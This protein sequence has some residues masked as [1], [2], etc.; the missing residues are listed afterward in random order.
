MLE[1]GGV[2]HQVWAD[3]AESLAL[4]F[5]YAVSEQLLGVGFWALGYDDGHEPLWSELEERYPPAIVEP[6]PVDEG[7]G[8]KDAGSWDA[9][10]PD[11][12]APDVAVWDAGS[13]AG[14]AR[15]PAF[16]TG[17]VPRVDSA[18]PGPQPDALD[19][20]PGSF[21][22]P[23]KGGAGVGG[24]G[25][26]GDPDTIAAGGAKPLSR[27]APAEGCRATGGSAP[28]WAAG[29]LAMAGVLAISRRRA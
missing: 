20:D 19:E 21:Y 11:T 7:P 15:V 14:D 18:A 24:P 17:A 10:S 2:W 9:G 26:G 29:L 25:A 3:T 1:Q 28:P 12:V 22:I 4:K 16:D 5:D 6:P 27:A 13:G 8:E 23:G